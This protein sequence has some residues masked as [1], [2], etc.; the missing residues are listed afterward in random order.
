M[1]K[2]LMNTN[3]KDNLEYSKYFNR[4]LEEFHFGQ[5]C[6]KILYNARILTFLFVDPF[7]C[8]IP[9]YLFLNEADKLK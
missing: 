6:S 8:M 2:S 3:M 1:L 5:V 9:H 4:L 7:L